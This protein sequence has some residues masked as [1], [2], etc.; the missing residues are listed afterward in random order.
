[1]VALFMTTFIVHYSGLYI[2]EYQS[3]GFLR[4]REIRV[5]PYP[6]R[7]IAQFLTTHGIRGGFADYWVSYP[8]TFFSQEQ[9][10]VVPNHRRYFGYQEYVSTLPPPLAY[11]FG[12]NDEKGLIFENYLKAESIQ[13]A[14]HYFKNYVVYLKGE[15]VPARSYRDG[16]LI[17]GAGLAEVY[18]VQ[19]GKR[20]WVP[21]L[22]TFDAC[23]FLWPDVQVIPD[24][25]ELEATPV[26]KPID[27]RLD[28]R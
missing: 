3:L 13:Y 21:D 9:T 10:I 6:L 7:E 15:G 1:M 19:Q 23:G 27:G 20:R 12:A 25:A 14:K 28:C 8:V 4:R 11:I 17:R 26:G 18:V 16:V 2:S 24:V 5:V 22:E